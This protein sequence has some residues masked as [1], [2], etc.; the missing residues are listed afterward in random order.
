MLS[1]DRL[2]WIEGW[3]EV[4][5]GAG[6]VFRPSILE[7][8]RVALRE[9][10]AGGV[11]VAL[12]GTGCS[13]GDAAL[14]AENI[15]LDLSRMDR[16][17]SWDG[18]TG[19]IDVEP[20]VTLRRLWRF[21]LGDGW[22]PPVV[23]GTM[24]TSVGGCLGMNVHGKNNWARGT[25]GE[26]CLEFDLMTADGELRT[27]S[28][29]D[30]PETFNAVIG[31]FGLLGVI[32][33]ARLQMK[34][35]T[36]GLVEAKAVSAGNLETLLRLT[37]EAKDQWEYVVGWIDAFPRGRKLGRG[38]L[39]F[40]RHLEPGEDA[41]P[42][43]TLRAEAQDLPEDVFMMP[44]SAIW[45]L[46]KPFTN[47]LGMKW[48]NRLKYLSGATLG[49]GAIYRQ[50]F[51]EFSFLL[52]YVPNWKRIYRPGG[53]IQHQSFVPVDQAEAVFR[54]QLEACQK[55]RLPSFLG[56]VKRHRP[57]DFLMGHGLD[58]FSL[59]LDFPVIAGRQERLWQLVRTMA[60]DVVDA[61]GRFY[62]AKDAA[63][64]GELYRASFREDQVERL[65]ALKAELDPQALLRTA[66]GD[67]LLEAWQ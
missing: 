20:G 31:S 53:L 34:K 67:R 19:I 46:I 18:E 29:N 5:G 6:Y 66:L 48:I 25:F 65:L 35:I 62:A 44:K 58:G 42:A 7:G 47:R 15:I 55:A 3:G 54:R 2:E 56:V 33:R 57:D 32:T 11:S 21:V 4:L 8:I 49:E 13:Y 43:Q 59:A 23:T 50:T 60:E 22:W 38:L 41:E 37:D 10:G 24:E 36:S 51:A 45:R 61:G 16:I 52:D 64:P 26:H 40:A 28:R 9:A 1:A 39:H 30:D 63:I 12:R 17:L 27:V 14:R